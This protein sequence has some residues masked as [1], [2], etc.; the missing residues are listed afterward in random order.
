MEI[1]I[2]S[3]IYDLNPDL[4]EYLVYNLIILRQILLLDAAKG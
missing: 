2:S 3:T 1:V 4:R